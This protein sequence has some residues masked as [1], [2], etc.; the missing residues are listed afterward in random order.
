MSDIK[1]RSILFHSCRRLTFPTVSFGVDYETR[2]YK[3]YLLILNPSS[4][5]NPS[6]IAGAS[7]KNPGLLP[8]FA[9]RQANGLLISFYTFGMARLK[10]EPATSRNQGT[11]EL[12]N[13][14]DRS[15]SFNK[16]KK[17]A[18]KSTNRKTALLVEY[19]W[20]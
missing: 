19:F 16:K 9:E 17:K 8:P 5:W 20:R 14:V 10:I 18:T 11:A 2:F 3:L 4:W 7:E 1:G 15:E 6:P 12:W 13:L